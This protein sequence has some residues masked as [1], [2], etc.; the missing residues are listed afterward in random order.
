MDVLEVNMNTEQFK[1]A[2]GESRNGTDR[3][4]R[5]PLYSRFHYSDGVEQCAEAGCY[6]LLDI[7]GTELTA[8]KL[9]ARFCDMLIVTV[10]VKDGEARIKGEHEDDD[11][12]PYKRKVD[13]TDLPEGKWTF[14]VSN[15]G[16]GVL[17]CLLP[18][19]Y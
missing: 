10:T 6:W 12:H 13:Y 11:K 15:D 17:R 14:Y 2:Y 4:H 1:Q 5:N 9:T 3:W 16:D 18:S 8:S 7:L 19:E